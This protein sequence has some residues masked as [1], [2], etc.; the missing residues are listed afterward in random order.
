MANR[1]GS[2][3]YLSGTV[4]VTL[5]F[6]EDFE[7]TPSQTSNLQTV[8]LL[9]SN[10]YIFNDGRQVKQKTIGQIWQKFTATA[11]TQSDIE[12]YFESKREQFIDKSG[13]LTYKKPDGSAQFSESGWFLR[14]FGNPTITP[15]LKG[16][17]WVAEYE[18]TFIKG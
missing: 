18:L 11:T 10:N 9:R 15:G 6:G 16:T 13:T 3:A 5:T 8:P 4:T 14:D 2:F 12:D 7:V 17:F 1:D